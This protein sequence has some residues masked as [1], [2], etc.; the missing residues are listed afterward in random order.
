MQD[1]LRTFLRNRKAAIGLT[2]VLAY[3]LIALVAPLIAPFDPIARVG[4][5]HQAPSAEHW[6][7]TTR[8]GR[9][10]FSQLIWGTRTSLMVGIVAGL[11]VTAIGTF[12]GIT[13]AYFGGLVDDVLNFFTN[14][15]LVLPQLP[16]LLVLAAFLGQVGP[17]AI[18]LI[19]GLT[20][21]A[22][23]A[24][25]TRAQ[26]M[27]LKTRDFI[28]AA[29]MIGEPTW[30]MILVEM[31]PNLLSIIG[32]NFIG[33]VIFTIITEA[34]LEFLGLGSP[35]ALSWGTMLYNAQTASAIM[36]GAWW[37]VLA[38]CGAIV[39]IGIGLSLMNFGVDE[40]ANPRMRTL[41]NVAKALRI[42]KRLLRQRMQEAN[43]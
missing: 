8:M 20:S 19:I 23:G 2:I 6:L 41:G 17:W 11:I 15:V 10:V 12:I 26:A 4:R 21:W 37:E 38:P 14:V 30:R 39:L 25:V 1:L 32:F 27:S 7:G 31:L 35:L 13:A 22:W 29:A 18:A 16:L 9:D 3:V 24:R 42:E 33:S 40:I 43:Q 36:V 5:P 34:T 28:Q